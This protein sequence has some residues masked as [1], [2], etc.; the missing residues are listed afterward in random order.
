MQED[1]F[2]RTGLLA[3]A[4]LLMACLAGCGKDDAVAVEK[5][6]PHRMEDPAYVQA[7]ADA[8]DGSKAL[9][10]KR[11]PVVEKMQAI[12]DRAK[13][14]GRKPTDYPEWAALEAE[15]RRLV[16]EIQDHN[17]ATQKLVRERI[18]QAMTEKE[19]KK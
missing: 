14:E 13:A 5:A 10:A 9:A 2:V 16:K 8:R 1:S 3:G 11:W 15:N 18:R 17:Q 19:G 7:L 12:V 6:P 4:V